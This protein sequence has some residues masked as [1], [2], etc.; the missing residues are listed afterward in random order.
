MGERRVVAKSVAKRLHELVER[1]IEAL[2][3]VSEGAQLCAEQVETLEKLAKIAKLA[4][5]LGAGAAEAPPEVAAL[6]DAELERAL[7]SGGGRTH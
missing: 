5:E 4:Q 3:G 1:E 2:D 6:S 7:S